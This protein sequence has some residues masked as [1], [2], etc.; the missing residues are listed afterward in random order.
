[1]T[2]SVCPGDKTSPKGNGA[3]RCR[4]GEYYLSD[5]SD[6]ICEACPRGGDCSSHDGITIAE[7]SAQVAHWRT[8]PASTIFLDCR[9]GYRGV[10]Y[11]Q[12][13]AFADERCCPLNA[14]TNTS[15]CAFLN[16]TRQSS[17]LDEQC[18]PAYRGPLCAGCAV[19]HVRVLDEC[20][21]CRGGAV[22][23]SAFGVLSLVSGAFSLCLAL[24]LVRCSTKDTADSLK[25]NSV[26]GQVKILLLFLQL[27]SAMP[28]AF[29]NVNWPISFKT[30]VLVVSMPVNL[31][32]LSVFALGSCTL[33]LFPLDAFLLHMSTP[34]LLVLAV[35]AAYMAT[36]KISCCVTA[37]AAAE[38]RQSRRQLS[39]KI[40]IFVIQLLYPGLATR[41][42]SIF[43]CREFAG[44]NTPVLAANFMVD[45]YST[46]HTKFAITGIFFMVLYVI[47]VPF[48]VFVLLWR[49]RNHLNDR[50]SVRHEVVKYE[51]GALYRQFEPSFWFFELIIITQKMIMTG[52]LSV[53]AQGSPLQ[54]LMAVMFMLGF[55]LITLKLSPF[56]KSADDLM[57]FIVSLAITLDSLAGF[58]L[59]MD[60]EGEHFDAATIEALLMAMNISVLVLIAGNMIMI[61]WGM[62][63]RLSSRFKTK[64]TVDVGERKGEAKGTRV[65]P[66]SMCS[67]KSVQGEMVDVDVGSE[68]A[69]ATVEALMAQHES[70]SRGQAE[71]Q[72]EMRKRS[73]RKTLAR[74][75]ARAVL[76]RSRKLKNVEIFRDF[77]D[78]ALAVVIGKMKGQLFQA[79]EVIVRQGDPADAFYVITEGTCIVKRK[80]LVNLVHGQVVGHLG[81]FEHFGEAALTTAAR[82]VFLRESGMSGNVRA[83]HRNA[84]VE[85]TPDASVHVLHLKTKDLEDVLMSGAVDIQAL[86]RSIE[87]RKVTRDAMTVAAQVWH[88]SELHANLRR[89]R[90]GR[91]GRS[92]FDE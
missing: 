75:E 29:D 72:E 50:T 31:D 37:A 52:A 47:G 40:V 35:L 80:T 71:K 51:F 84:S 55:T 59:L 91:G 69:E 68:S 79:G 22:F 24:V 6:N 38:V 30:F 83:G 15:I 82:R 46:R 28:S 76:K 53:V 58:V 45:C 13:Q 89:P 26:V 61:K 85:V 9:E 78:A 92:L 88:R 17:R 73:H 34:P 19:G 8:G 25:N 33:S 21:L 77:N 56:R 86:K 65:A 3:C 49:N 27:L 32:F 43:R 39:I 81:V 18:A 44:V 63:E 87:D 62:W 64:E 67:D 12:A 1:M 60:R 7:V 23:A 57:S 16:L 36:T 70:A 11:A 4:K 90:G 74:V 54:L 20:V 5:P 42:F 10:P 66:A 14:T 2:C 41:V 48:L